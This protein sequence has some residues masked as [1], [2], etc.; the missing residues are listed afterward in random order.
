MD[1]EQEIQQAAESNLSLDDVAK[2]SESLDE[3]IK[4]DDLTP[5]MIDDE[6]YEGDGV[7]KSGR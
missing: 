2:V 7:R 5:E 6:M 3:H 4:N 1:D